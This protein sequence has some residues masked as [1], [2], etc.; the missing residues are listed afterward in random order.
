MTLDRLS[1][2]VRTKRQTLYIG[3]ELAGQQGA[4]G[5]S[6][7][8]VDV[9]GPAVVYFDGCRLTDCHFEGAVDELIWD[10]PESRPVV[11]GAILLRDCTFTRCNF[12]DVGVAGGHDDVMRLLQAAAPV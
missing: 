3:R 10:V 12:I 4:A 5:A 6:F 1:G 7:T 9:I 2:M 8:D 11:R